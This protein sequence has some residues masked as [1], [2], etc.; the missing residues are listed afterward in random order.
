MQH[1]E[2]IV[3]GGGMLGPAIGYG[4]ACQGLRTAILDD[5]DR[6]L[7]AARG[8]FGLVWY[9]GKGL[10]MSRYV[11]WTLESTALW[12]EFAAELRERTGVDTG[13]RK[14]GGLDLCVGGE[15]LARS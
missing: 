11:H 9:Q 3:V 1:F 2:V 13:Y 6:A 15:E 8:N 12:P 7:R 5:G 10:G 14:T 4:L